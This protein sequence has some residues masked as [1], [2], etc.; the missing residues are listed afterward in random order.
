M[1]PLAASRDTL[2]GPGWRDVATALQAF[3]QVNRCH[4][5]IRFSTGEHKG[6][7]DLMMEVIAHENKDQI[8]DQCSLASVRCSAGVQGFKTMEA[9]T[10]F[11]LY[12][13]DFSLAQNEFAG[14]VIKRG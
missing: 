10:L 2:S 3:E 13:L 5:E 12:Q 7:P 1:P 14:V 4:L 6:S 8:G 9:V 11:L